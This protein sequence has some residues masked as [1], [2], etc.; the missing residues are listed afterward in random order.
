MGNAPRE[1][2]GWQGQE[3]ISYG[4][5]RQPGRERGYL[6][7]LGMEDGQIDSGILGREGLPSIV[8]WKTEE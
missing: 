1:S 4:G 5:Q 3:A 6:L 7:F 8:S 2:Q